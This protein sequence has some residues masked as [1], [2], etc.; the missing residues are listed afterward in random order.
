MNTSMIG[1][2]RLGDDLQDRPCELFV[3]DDSP[4]KSWY[5][6]TCATSGEAFELLEEQVDVE[7]HADGRDFSGRAIFMRTHNLVA[8]ERSND[9]PIGV[10]L[11]G[12]GPLKEAQ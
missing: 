6:E 3:D 7:V 2:C 11:R 10:E 8:D 12:T 4:L 1:T 5:L 9:Y